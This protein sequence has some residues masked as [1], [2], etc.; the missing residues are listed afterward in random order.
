MCECVFRLFNKHF[1]QRIKL[2]HVVLLRT[3]AKWLLEGSLVWFTCRGFLLVTVHRDWSVRKVLYSWGFILYL[4][5]E[6]ENVI[7]FFTITENQIY[8]KQP[9]DICILY[10]VVLRSFAASLL[11]SAWLAAAAALTCCAERTGRFF[12][13]CTF[14]KGKNKI[15][16]NTRAGWRGEQLSI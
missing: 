15:T 5:T 13:G 3:S 12:L 6:T 11:A 9:Q 14:W 2:L 7:F 4:H 1:L 8:I 10:K 16:H